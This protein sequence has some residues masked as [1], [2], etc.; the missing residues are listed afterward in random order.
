MSAARLDLTIEQGTTFLRTCT[1]KDAEGVPVDITDWEFTGQIRMHYDST[2]VAAAFDFEILDQILYPGKFTFGLSPE[3]SSAIA[4]ATSGNE[5]CKKLTTYLYDIEAA[6]PG[7]I[8]DRIL[9]GRVFVSPEVT[10]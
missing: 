4:V 6:R 1:I 10:R 3:D 5:D 7:D 2:T 8:T 9:E